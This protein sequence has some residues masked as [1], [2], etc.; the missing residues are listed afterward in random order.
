MINW[1]FLDPTQ[2]SSHLTQLAAQFPIPFWAA[3]GLI[4][5]LTLWGAAFFIQLVM[6]RLG[7]HDRL[8]KKYLQTLATTYS[9]IPLFTT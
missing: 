2:A 8:R 6:K 7:G 3:V 5:G 1:L 4:G 9:Q